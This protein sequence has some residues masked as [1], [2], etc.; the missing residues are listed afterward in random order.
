M[1]RILKVLIANILFVLSELTF[2][3]FLIPLNSSYNLKW[4]KESSEKEVMLFTVLYTTF[5]YNFFGVNGAIIM[6][7]IAIFLPLLYLIMSN[8]S[9]K[10]QK[11]DKIAI[12]ALIPAGIIFTI[13]NFL[14]EKLLINSSKFFE[15]LNKIG[16]IKSNISDNELKKIIVSQLSE[17]EK[18]SNGSILEGA[19]NSIELTIVFLSMDNRM[20]FFKLFLIFFFIVL[21]IALVDEKSKFREW[22]AGYWMLL[23]YIISEFYT[24]II[25]IRVAKNIITE[26]GVVVAE[27]IKYII[28][29][30]FIIW[31]IK[32][33]N[34]LLKTRRPI[35]VIRIIISAIL[36]LAFPKFVFIFGAAK[37][38]FTKKIIK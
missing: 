15:I 14:W 32:E 21:F 13:Y 9:I 3:Q 35:K 1:I 38:F 29:I 4:I 36:L 8:D 17:I 25:Y 33:L 26:N 12:A 23:P 5:V 7:T 18:M 16:N 20:V 30:I 28:M 10:I 24:K 6:F 27:N 11:M 34:M 31:G 37:S 19:K 2:F 22:R